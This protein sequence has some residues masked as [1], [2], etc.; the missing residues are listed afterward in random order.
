MSSARATESARW[1]AHSRTLRDEAIVNCARLLTAAGKRAD[2]LELAKLVTA[3]STRG[4][5]I[6]ELAK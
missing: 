6:K 3:F 5:L 4:D 2:A 1:L